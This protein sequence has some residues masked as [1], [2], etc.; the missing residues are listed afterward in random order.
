MCTLLCAAHRPVYK[1]RMVKPIETQ[2]LILRQWQDE[3]RPHFARINADPLIMEYMPRLLPP[4]DSDKLVERF[5]KH[6]KKHGYGMYAVERKEDG[7][8]IGTV[9]LN[10]VE[11]KAAFTPAVEIA[12]RLDYGAW[13]HGY[14]TEAA[15]ALIEYAFSELKLKEILS[16]TVHDNTASTHMME[17]LGM[18][19]DVKGDFDYPGMRKD[20]PLGKFVLYRLRQKDYLAQQKAA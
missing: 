20:H 3:D 12:W 11:F 9:G 4:A 17:K 2:R 10:N 13:G 5:K 14:A 15:R 7:A 8:F 6:I 1:H 18:T 16:F 19:R